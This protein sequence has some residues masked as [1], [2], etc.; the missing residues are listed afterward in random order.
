MAANEQKIIE[1]LNAAQ[2]SPQDVGGYYKPKDE[3]GAK[4]MRPSPTMNAL[5]DGF[6]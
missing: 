2:G 5:I 6:N 4:L 1:E 3:L